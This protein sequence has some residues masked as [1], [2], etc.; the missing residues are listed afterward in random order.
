MRSTPSSPARTVLNR[1]RTV[2]G[3]SFVALAL[4][5]LAGCPPPP[6]MPP[7]PD[8]TDRPV[9]ETSFLS[10]DAAPGTMQNGGDDFAGG[11]G[12]VADP[13]APEGDGGDERTVEEG[14]IYR[15]LD[16]Q[17]IAN[18]NAYRGLQLI[19]F[20][21]VDA[22]TI[23]G[24]L[25]VSGY[26]V[27]MYVD[28]DT[29]YVLMNDWRGYYGVRE[30]VAVEQRE[31]GVVLA[32]DISDPAAPVELARAFVPG[33]I[34]TSRLTK[35]STTGALYVVTGGYAEWITDD[36]E[37]VW[38]TRTVVKSFDITGASLTPRTELDL[39]G[40]VSDI[41]AT[42]DVLI[43][44]R[45][46]W[47][48]DDEGSRVALIDIS[49]PSGQMVEG[50]EVAVA[51]RVESQFNLDI[52]GDILRVVSGSTW[53]GTNTNHLQTYDVSDLNNLV[54]VDHQTF[55]D[56]EQLY[57]TLFLGNK[58]FF[59]TYFRVDPFHAFSIDDDGMAAEQSEFIVS[60]WNDFFRATFDASRLV[61]IGINDEEGQTLSVS[62]YDITD[63]TNPSPL[64]A[65]EEVDADQSWSEANWDHRAFS[66]LEDVTSVMS[67][68]ADPVEETG[69]VLLPFSGWSDN[70]SGYT[71][72]VQIF[73]FSET[74]LTRRGLMVHGTPV[75]RSFQ[76]DDDLTANLSEAALSFFDTADPDTPAALGEVE[77]APNYTDVF[78]FGDYR[79]RLKNNR[80]TYSYWWG[81]DVDLP[82][83]RVDIIPADEHPDTATPVAGFEV[84]AD[85]TLY[86]TGDLLVATR[87]VPVETDTWPY[88]YEAHLTVFDLSM[89]AMPVEAGELVTQ[90]IQPGS[91][92][93]WYDYG[94]D[95]CFD[96]GGYYPG[97][98][99]ATG[100][101]QAIDGGLVFLERHWNE[102]LVGQEES[103]QTWISEPAC[104]GSGGGVVSPD[105]AEPPPDGEETE[106]VD[107]EPADE[108]PCEGY[109]SGSIR[110]TSLD[111]APQVCSG[112]LQYCTYGDD[113][114]TCEP[115]DEDEVATETHC[116]EYDRYRYWNA[117]SLEVLDLSDPS[118]P[119]LADTVDLPVG[120][121]GVGMLAEGDHVW[122]SYRQ[123]ETVEGDPLPYVRYFIRPVDVSTPASPDV[124]EGVNVPGELLATA[125]RP[126]GG[127]NVYTRDQMWMD[128]V[129]VTAAHR[130]RLDG[131]LAYLEAS[132]VFDNQFVQTM[133]LDGAGH[134]LVSHRDASGYGYGWG[135][136]YGEEPD[137]QKMTVL[138]TDGL[139]VQS[140]V[141]V[142]AWANLRDA[143]AGRALFEVP[144]GLLVF[145]L[146][147]A[148][149]P[150]PQSYFATRGWPSRV[151][152][153]GDEVVFAAGRY[154]V[155]AFGLDTF[156]L[157][158]PIDQQ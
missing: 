129:V 69:L 117:F 16:G 73:S 53:G 4:A 131:D 112:S 128:N 140:A 47:S 10:A 14:D 134:L 49:D 142:D 2:V 13:S 98:G 44:A 18:L 146:D 21:D 71:A 95:D 115:V 126:G 154:G 145:N 80:D 38:E 147:D 1:V 90:Q 81:G 48:A 28:G 30:E 100:D 46:D 111:G 94:F 6:V 36:G 62:L 123:P 109:Y 66:V 3:T 52:H 113:E 86:A 33:H 133:T 9:G 31:G 27:E 156:N 104:G 35:A 15:V 85:A 70:D 124:G 50:G 116:Y 118:D 158:P 103:C 88:T 99:G 17:I 67:P 82:P 130:L 101:V 150:Y 39:G 76:P 122:V 37:W 7:P 152:I 68:G 120:D 63:L 91:W 121:E 135:W 26:P 144:G 148:S 11:D 79:A 5:A 149:A 54:P 20:S 60:G 105:P 34:Q 55:G 57:A 78:A 92:G 141:D 51:G 23:V 59:V 138:D 77:L 41:Q 19:D 119:T 132:H 96:C 42:P 29:A 107:E 25:Q 153:E 61:G 74:T 65:R 139:D 157:L 12:D 110:C 24:R 43:V 151:G 137:L 93:G 108:E 56:N 114:V 22:P 8:D 32:V 45:W 136:G 83:S 97:Y 89:P 87:F 127:T 84:P 64:L 72:A 125:P 58:A 75:R 155:Y 40:Y 106:P 102:E 143:V